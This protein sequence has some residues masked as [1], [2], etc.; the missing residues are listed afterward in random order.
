MRPPLLTDDA[1]RAAIQEIQSLGRRVTGVAVRALLLRRYG[2]RGGVTRV[3]RVLAKATTPVLPAAIPAYRS[4]S[5][6]SREAAIARAEV[7]E[8]RERVHQARWAREMD[9][10]RHQAEATDRIQQDMA[11]HRTR[12]TELTRA[13]ASAHA[14]IVELERALQSVAPIIPHE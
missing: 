13:L 4:A 9:A 1:I 8:E 3:Y 2:A 5:D 10:L 11:V 6:E 12:V 7:A 14:R